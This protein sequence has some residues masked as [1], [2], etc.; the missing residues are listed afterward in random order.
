MKPILVSGIQPTGKLH[1]GNYLGALKNFV[2]LQNS[3]N[4]DCFFFIAD[5]HSLT[6]S[7]TP[8]E[9][10]EQISD[11]FLTYLAAGL[12]PKKS[13]LFQQSAIAEH[14][15][16]SWILNTITPFGELRRMTQFKDKSENESENTNVGLFDYPVLMAA[17]ILIYSASV[18]PVG[19]DQLQHLELTRT[20]ARKFN[21]KFGKTFFEPKPLLTSV[22]R[23]M[24]L[25]DPEKKMS[26]SRSEGCL[27]IDDEPNIIRKK[28]QRAVTDSEST[29]EYNPEKRPGVSNLV[30][31][32][33]AIT[34]KTPKEIVSMYKE[35]GYAD[36][37]RDLGD[38]LVETFGPF[39]EKKREL[40]KKNIEAM[41]DEGNKEA[42]KH[43]S[44]SYEIIKKKVG[45]I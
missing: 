19:D 11:L 42:R 33:S 39:Q 37:K 38:A 30:L 27:F 23:L 41:L 40:K 45:L 4:Y 29:I 6:E 8:K 34:N 28:I 14:S 44:K 7:Y 35:K 31:I 5:L 13:V 17:D 18:V 25:D 15:E 12:D 43:A 2:E 10:K 9:K 3:G 21:S 22:P 1:L 36:F 32:Y 24:S 16:L 26:K 20:L